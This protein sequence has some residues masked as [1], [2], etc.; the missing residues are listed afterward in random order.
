MEESCKELWGSYEK[1]LIEQYVQ[2]KQPFSVCL[3]LTP[4]C[5]FSCPMCYIRLTPEQMRAQGEPLSTERW[6]QIIDE[7]SN[8]GALHLEMTGGEILTRADFPELYE[9]AYRKGL[10]INLKTNGYLL[11]EKT[12]LLLERCKPRLVEITLYGSSDKTYQAFCGVPDGFSVVSRNI[13]FLQEWGIRVETPMTV[14]K[15]NQADE[16]AVRAWAEQRGIHFSSYTGLIRPIRTAE[17]DVSELWVQPTEAESS[18]TENMR[19]RSYTPSNRNPLFCRG[20]GAKFCVSWDGR[21]TLCNGFTMIWEDVRA[22]S[23]QAAFSRLNERLSCLKRPKACDNCRYI[24][25]CVACPSR[26]QS[27]T[28]GL[29]TVSEALCSV[30]RKNYRR[31]LEIREDET[32]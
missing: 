9:Y 12:L 32:E 19:F 16:E 2:R 29:E 22:G 3:E 26:L 15:R 24:D 28:G 6:K 4:L 31:I 20:F 10:L 11:T 8:M 18:I 25:F 1:E 30:A 17:R 21:M 14:T 13:E 7:V 27:E 23:L 5:N